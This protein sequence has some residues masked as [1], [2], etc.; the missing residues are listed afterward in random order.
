MSAPP[1]PER[2]PEERLVGPRRI[3][4]PVEKIAKLHAAGM[5]LATLAKRYGVARSVIRDRL[6]R[7]R[8]ATP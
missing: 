6:A 2:R 4:L 1:A 7:A 3:D 8:E 5:S